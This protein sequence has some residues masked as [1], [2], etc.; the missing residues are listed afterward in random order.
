VKDE[1][2]VYIRCPN[3]QCPAQL[4]ERLRYFA[5]RNAMDIE[6]LGDK[7]VDQLVNT[8]LV[9]SYGDL[10]RLTAEQLMK[11]ERM[12][13]KSSE[14]LIAAIDASKSRGL[15]RLL[16]ALSIRHVGVRV[17]TVLAQHFGSMKEL[18]AASVQDLANVDE[19]G[20]VIAA[21]VHDWLHSE[22]G[23]QNIQDLTNLGVSMTSPRAA[24]ETTDHLLSGKTFVVTGTLKKYGRDDIEDLIA[25]LGGRA[26]SSVS[27][28]TDYLI[29][30]AEAGSKLA[31]AQQL[32][33]TIL[34]EED[35][36]KMIADRTS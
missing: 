5:T 23:R 15:A 18:H 21:K 10:Y 33:I 6:G 22:F 26:T 30:G 8:G 16:N 28:K 11:V 3:P 35:F 34:S 19:I 17:A 14:S 25:K 24:A 29:A 1:G 27:A 13:K 36:E 20:S 4:K 32:G 2:G 9:K 7:L 12:G 31:K